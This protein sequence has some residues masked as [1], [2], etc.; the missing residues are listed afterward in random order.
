MHLHEHFSVED[1]CYAVDLA[2]FR[3]NQEGHA[4]VDA[5]WAE[6]HEEELTL[7]KGQLFAYDTHTFE[8]FRKNLNR[9]YGGHV[10]YRWDGYQMWSAT[11][12][13]RKMMI[14]FSEMSPAFERLPSVPEKYT[15]WFSLKG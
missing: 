3:T 4:T 10:M 5:L 6:I 14:A 8:Q 13:F 11:N 15:G 7:C 12:D 1:Y 2:T 9:R